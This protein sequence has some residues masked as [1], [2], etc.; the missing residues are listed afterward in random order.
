MKIGDLIKF[1]GTWGKHIEPGERLF[2][3]V[4]QVWTNGGT[5]NQ[6]SCEV[7]WDNGD[8]GINHRINSMEVINAT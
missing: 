1:K 8:Y 4:I 3:I 7:L 6:Q 2:G 5:R